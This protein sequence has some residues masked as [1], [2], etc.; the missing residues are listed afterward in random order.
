MPKERHTINRDRREADDGEQ[1]TCPDCGETFDTKDRLNRHRDRVKRETLRGSE[2]GD[3]ILGI[4][5]R[6]RKERRFP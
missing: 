3:A 1:F 4:D 2:L 5:R 6:R